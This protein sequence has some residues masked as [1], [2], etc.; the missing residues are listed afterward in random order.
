MFQW[1]TLIFQNISRSLFGLI[2]PSIFRKYHVSSINLQFI[3]ECFLHYWLPRQHLLSSLQGDLF[4][5]LSHFV[6]STQIALKRYP[7]CFFI[8]LQ[9]MHDSIF[10]FSFPCKCASLYSFASPLITNITAKPWRTS[11]NAFFEPATSF[12]FDSFRFC[13]RSLQSKSNKRAKHTYMYI[14]YPSFNFQ[15]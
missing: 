8:V 9:S 5:I 7:V 14:V 3:I 10:S 15:K 4:F 11:F 1:F 2:S 13:F 6:F 12:C